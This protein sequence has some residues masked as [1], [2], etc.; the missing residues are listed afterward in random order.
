[1]RYRYVDADDDAL[2]VQPEAPGAGVYLNT[3]PNGVV[4]PPADVPALIAAIRIAAG[5]EEN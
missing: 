5:L 4:V 3:D 2:T 1:M